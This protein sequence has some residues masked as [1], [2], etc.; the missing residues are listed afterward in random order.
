MGKIGNGFVS[1]FKLY[2][3]SK[4]YTVRVS[5]EKDSKNRTNLT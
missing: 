3:D 2:K 5:V 4:I 1:Y